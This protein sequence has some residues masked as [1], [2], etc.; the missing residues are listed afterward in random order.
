MTRP[1]WIWTESAGT[2]LS[3]SVSLL[4]AGFGD[5][6][7][8]RQPDGINALKQNWD[9]RGTEIDDDAAT[10]MVAFLRARNGAEAFEYTPMWETTAVLVTCKEWTRSP[11][12][13]P[14]YSDFTAKFVRSYEP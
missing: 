5:G 10:E 12:Q 8:Q 2:Q 14:G 7:V 3:D 11:S 13:T 4:E 6:Y 9:F 1:V